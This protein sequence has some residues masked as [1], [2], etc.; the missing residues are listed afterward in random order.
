[1][2]RPIARFRLTAF[3]AAVFFFPFF[4]FLGADRFFARAVFTA[5]RFFRFAGAFLLVVFLSADDGII[6]SRSDASLGV[7]FS[8]SE[9]GPL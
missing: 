3:F 5:A 8:T 7:T 6:P 1:L 4:F 9:K 2:R